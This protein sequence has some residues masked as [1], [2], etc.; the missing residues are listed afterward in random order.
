MA[1]GASSVVRSLPRGRRM[2]SIFVIPAFTGYRRRSRYCPYGMRNPT[3][4]LGEPMELLER[5]DAGGPTSPRSPY[6]DNRMKDE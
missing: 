5:V 1:A 4:T 2:A 6:A 3:D